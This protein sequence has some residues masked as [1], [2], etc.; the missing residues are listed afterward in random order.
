MCNNCVRRVAIA[1]ADR[2]AGPYSHVI[3]RPQ[4]GRVINGYT[5]QALF[6]AMNAALIRAQHQTEADVLGRTDLGRRAY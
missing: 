5:G 3:A 2:D 1:P 4:P 6:D